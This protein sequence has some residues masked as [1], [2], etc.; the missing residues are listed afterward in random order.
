[1]RSMK[2]PLSGNGRP[3]QADRARRPADIFVSADLDWMDFGQQHD[4]IKAV[5]RSNL[6]GNRIVIVAPKESTFTLKI[7]PHFD[8]A[9]ALKGGRL[10]MGNIDAVPAGTERSRLRS[11]VSGTA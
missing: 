8:L 10:A 2:S 4:L 5:S 11:S 1:M 9:G 3:A 6:L 7:A